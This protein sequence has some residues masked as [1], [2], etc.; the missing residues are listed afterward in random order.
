MDKNGYPL[1]LFGHFLHRNFIWFLLGSYAVAAAAPRAGLAIKDFSL[2]RFELFGEHIP[3]SLPMLLLALLLLNA[4]LG[5]Q[6]TQL[7]H[8]L[9]RPW[10]L[11]AGLAANLFIPI[12]YIF[13]VSQTMRL[14]HNPDEVQNILVGLALVASMPIAGSSTA[15]TQNANGD[16]SLSLGLVLGSTLLS[17]LTTPLA[18]HSVGL[19]TTGDYSEDLHELAASGTTGGF[20]AACVILPSLLG[21]LLRFSAG[22]ERVT[23]VKPTLK[24]LNSINLLVLN[25][26]N[27]SVSLPKA[28]SDPD[29]D[30]LAVTG[31]IVC[32]LCV[33]A[34]GAGWIIARLLRLEAPRQTS[35]MF[36]LGMNNNGTGLV[37]A[38]L[39][40]GDHELVML[41]IIFYNLVQHLVA[42]SIDFLLFRR[43]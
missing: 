26:S 31:I 1:S 29:L 41:P 32:G 7:R 38:A 19:M 13:A 24:L 42:G 39:M 4:G 30:F 9:L 40:L 34:F 2:G 3:L 21:I 23:P 11:V 12:A 20:L 8:L 15:W 10:S 14:W 17:P 35:L 22:E 25:Y 33:L 27:A 43:G 28:I 5:V 18:L 37:L 36:G 6:T 16:L